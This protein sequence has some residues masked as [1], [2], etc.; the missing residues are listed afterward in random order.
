MAK[1]KSNN[2]IGAI[3]I[4]KD[5]ILSVVEILS[6]DDFYDNRNGTIYKA[7]ISLFEKRVPIDMVTLTDQLE[8]ENELQNAGGSSYI[9]S[10]VNSTPSAA[11]VS[12]W[13]NIVRDKAL[14]RRLITSAITISD[15]GFD[16]NEEVSA[17]LDKAEQSL[18]AVSQKFFRQ[19]FIPIRD[20]LTEAFDRIDKIHK[21]KGA[22]RGIPTGFRDLDSKL[23][24]LQKSDLVILAARPSMGKTSLALNIAEH[25]SV[26]EKI[27]VAFF[28]LEMSK[29]QMVDRLISSQA[30]VDSWK[31]RTGNL[32]DEDFPK[33]GYA[34]G[35]LSEAPF[36]IDDSPALTVTEIRAKARR[37]QME[38]PL[39]A[40][41]VD[42]LQL[43][44]GRSRSSDSNRVQEISEIS[45]SLKA[46]SRELDIPVVAMSQLSRAVEHRPDKRPQLSDLRE[47]GC[48]S[49]DTLVFDPKNGLRLPIKD[50]VDKNDV[51]V[52]A[53]DSTG[54]IVVMSTSKIFSTGRKKVFEID[55]L[56]TPRKYIFT[57]TRNEMSDISWDHIEKIESGEIVEVF[58]ITVPKEHNFVAND[59]I[60]HNSIEQDAD[61]V[62]FIY[63]DEYY[64]ENSDKKGVS[65]ILIRKHRNGPIGNVELFFNAEQMRFR[66]LARQPKQSHS[67]FAPED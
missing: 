38:Q 37:L 46:L 24:G 21:D 28:S 66:D 57:K 14:L 58:D 67:D 51:N 18:F 41:F 52:S 54:K 27:P 9:V 50:L 25:I 17:V 5:A 31:L 30:G 49:G 55:L 42:Y 47:S 32:S 63:R 64:D 34:M 4:D 40:I 29:E 43:I 1:K 45:R 7:I 39:G 2:L 22:L 35:T 60:V 59:I 62:M 15:L 65:E 13:A 53:I 20:V 56:A 12:H 11:N 19:K 6:S 3:L 61:V 10:L 8:K 33:I 48:L 26:E 23:A 36:F 44:E 16:E